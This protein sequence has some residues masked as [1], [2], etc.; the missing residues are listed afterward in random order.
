MTGRPAST[1]RTLGIATVARRR[2]AEASLLGAAAIGASIALMGTSAWLISRAA[3]HPSEA[4]LTLAI[5]GVQ[6]SGSPGLLPLRRTTRRPRCGSGLVGRPPSAGLRTP[7]GAGTGRAA[8]V[9]GA[10]TWWRAWWTTSTHCRTWCFACCSR[11]LLA[12]LV[13]T[14]TVVALWWFL[15]QAG[16]VL[17][18]ALAISATAVPWLTGRLA[19]RAEA[20]QATS[21]G[22]AHSRRRRSDRRR[23]RTRGHGRDLRPAQSALR[24]PTVELRSIARRGAG[25]TGIGLTLAPAL[26]RAGQLGCPDAGCPGRRRRVPRRRT[27]SP[28]LALV[29]LAAFE[30][31]LA[32]AS[33]DPG[34]AALTGRPRVLIFEAMD[35]TPVVTRIPQRPI[36]LGRAPHTLRAAR[37]LGLLPEELGRRPLFAR[38]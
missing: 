14:G 37:R 33:G 19:T 13:G 26:G 24:R 21:A 8:R 35:A 1:A 3:Q 22:R 10:A 29:P 27:C 4:S 6:F 28:L 11:W 31:R 30:L 36:D 25:T 20:K 34:P 12:V 38:G 2:L 16:L 7:G 15:P 17:L 23:T 9:P 18:V 5:V 32:P